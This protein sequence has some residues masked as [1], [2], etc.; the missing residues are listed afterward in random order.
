MH[1]KYLAFLSLETYPLWLHQPSTLT[2]AILWTIALNCFIRLI[3]CL[4]LAFGHC[5]CRL[6]CH[7]DMLT[8]FVNGLC[9]FSPIWFLALWNVPIPFSMF[10]ASPRIHH[11]L[12]GPAF[13]HWTTVLEIKMWMMRHTFCYGVLLLVLCGSLG[14]PNKEICVDMQTPVYT[15]SERHICKCLC[16]HLGIELTILLPWCLQHFH[17]GHSLLP[18]APPWTKGLEE[19]HLYAY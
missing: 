1:R 2:R 17:C 4:S 7:F 10:P 19:A 8:W 11:L 18:L 13:F 14:Q 3:M 9:L 12:K 16:I 15:H 6:L 5:S